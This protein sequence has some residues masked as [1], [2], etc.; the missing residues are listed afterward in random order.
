M[1]EDRVSLNT[2]ILMDLPIFLWLLENI[3]SDSLLLANLSSIPPFC[4]NHRQIQNLN[5]Y[6]K[7]SIH[8]MSLVSLPDRTGCKGVKASGQS[9]GGLGFQERNNRQPE[10]C[11]VIFL[12]PDANLERSSGGETSREETRV[13][14][15]INKL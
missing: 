8:T 3:V 7:G 1:E 5:D 4:L 13:L 2:M 6:E 14:S 12:L 11:C 10:S 15:L 9:P